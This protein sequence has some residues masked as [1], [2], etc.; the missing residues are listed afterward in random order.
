[1]DSY[2][3]LNRMNVDKGKKGEG[4]LPFLRHLQYQ[5]MLHI[6]FENQ[7]VMRHVPIHLD[8][9]KFYEKVVLRNRGG[10][11]YELN[12]L[13]HWLLQ[14]LGYSSH[15]V[16]GTVRKP[17]GSWA[18]DDSHA[19]IL[20][21]LHEP[22][23]VDVGFGDSVRIPVPLSGEAIDD[24]VGVYRVK[25]GKEDFLF[26]VE[27]NK[28]WVTL[29]RFRPEPKNLS[30]FTPMC[31]YNQTSPNSR[32]TQESIA[33]KALERGRVTLLDNTLK[34]IENDNKTERKIHPTEKSKI[35]K[36]YFGIE[37]EDLSSS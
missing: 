9:E 33:T 25:E 12:G 24:G 2:L 36:K 8:I 15:L 29:Y 11:C 5:H 14:E 17:D 4:S 35:L 19:A 13:F 27:K 23:L 21:S 22:Y 28:E 37:L 32:F 20:V 7:D 30:D 16:S 10:F 1:M 34:I 3:Y 31:H 6:P 18:L 26:E